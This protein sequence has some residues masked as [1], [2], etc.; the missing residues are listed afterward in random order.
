MS[1]KQNNYKINKNEKNINK[2]SKNKQ[3]IFFF[4]KKG[5]IKVNNQKWQ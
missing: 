3:F 5:Q 2:I 1:K 4:K